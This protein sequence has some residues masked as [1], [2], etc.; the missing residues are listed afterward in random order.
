MEGSG[1]NRLRKD[2]VLASILERMDW[3]AESEPRICVWCRN[4]GIVMCDGLW[5]YV[6]LKAGNHRD[7]NKRM[8]NVI[9]PFPVNT[10]DVRTG[11]QCVNADEMHDCFQPTK[12]TDRR[13]RLMDMLGLMPD[14]GK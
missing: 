13:I 12:L 4:C 14:D 3:F 11:I 2:G 9:Q 1:S 6:C 7:L 8:K 5:G 10:D